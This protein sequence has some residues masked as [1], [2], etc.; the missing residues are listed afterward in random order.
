MEDCL[1]WFGLVWLQSGDESFDLELRVEVNAERKVHCIG[2]AGE[3]CS[4]CF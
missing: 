1:L 2:W 3:E 4:S